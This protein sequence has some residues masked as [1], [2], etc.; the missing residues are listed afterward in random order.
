MCGI[1]CSVDCVLCKRQHVSVQNPFFEYFVSVAV[2]KDILR[3]LGYSSN[4][5]LHV[6]LNFASRKSR[7]SSP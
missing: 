5:G 1:I 7:R 4:V 3:V 6:E 2:W